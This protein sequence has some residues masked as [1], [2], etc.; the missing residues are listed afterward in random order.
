MFPRLI[1]VKTLQD[2][3]GKIGH[4]RRWL[5]EGGKTRAGGGI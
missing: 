4:I 1:D 5:G 2:N 3:Q